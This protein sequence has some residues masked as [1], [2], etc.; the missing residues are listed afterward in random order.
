M[1]QATKDLVVNIFKTQLKPVLTCTLFCLCIRISFTY[2]FNPCILWILEICLHDNYMSL[3]ML[4]QISM[5]CLCL[6]PLSCF[7][8]PQNILCLYHYNSWRCSTITPK[9]CS[10]IAILLF[11]IVY[12]QRM[13]RYAAPSTAL[14]HVQQSPLSLWRPLT[15]SWER[16]FFL[17]SNCWLLQVTNP[18]LQS[19]KHRKVWRIG[20]E[21]LIME[22]QDQ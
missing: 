15:C 8:Y 18:P 5:F 20:Y 12:W 1:W 14:S 16:S 4:W 3:K 22:S 13:W 21:E 17:L 11:H 7:L 19:P 10:S 9:Y 6:V 2:I